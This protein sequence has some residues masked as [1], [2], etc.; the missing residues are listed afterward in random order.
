MNG[1]HFKYI[2]YCIEEA[3]DELKQYII[4]YEDQNKNNE[5]YTNYSKETIQKFCQCQ[6]VLL[7]AAAMLERI[8]WL[9]KAGD[10]ESSFHKE[11]EEKVPPD[12]N[13]TNPYS[14]TIVR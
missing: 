9:I 5:Y 10:T 7:R 1:E 8:D 12:I 4:N 11:W 3:A 13:I 2:Q 14:P 6:N